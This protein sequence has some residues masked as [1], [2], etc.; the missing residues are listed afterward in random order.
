M[1]YDKFKKIVQSIATE[2]LKKIDRKKIE[3]ALSK[4]VED[5]LISACMGTLG[6]KYDGWDRVYKLPERIYGQKESEIA[7]K[8]K[9]KANSE[10]DRLMKS[11]DLSA[12]ELTAADKKAI[13]RAY[14]KARRERLEDVASNLAIADANDVVKE[15]LS[16]LLRETKE[17]QPS[18]ESDLID[19]VFSETQF[20]GE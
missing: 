8:I 2:S 18:M 19:V 4:R 14:K 1:D 16:E 15:T 17:E 7:K 11:V 3:E 5:T 20:E 9:E 10:A 13:I 6:F 12:V